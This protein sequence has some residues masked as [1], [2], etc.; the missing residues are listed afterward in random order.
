M[1]NRFEEAAKRAA[2]KANSE[3]AEEEAKLTSLTWEDLQKMLPDPIDQ[4]QLDELMK[5]VQDATD[6]NVK[7]AKLIDNINSLGACR[8]FGVSPLFSTTVIF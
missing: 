4:E 6:H 5:I 1:S 8:T 2:A 3:L 7:V